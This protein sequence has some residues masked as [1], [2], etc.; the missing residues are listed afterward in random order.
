MS[1]LVQETRDAVYHVVL[2]QHLG[3]TDIQHFDTALA[4]RT[5]LASGHKLDTLPDNL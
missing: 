3:V 2:Y 4:G 1:R 5:M